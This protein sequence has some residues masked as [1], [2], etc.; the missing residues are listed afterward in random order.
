MS[1]RSAS[2]PLSS[3]LGIVALAQTTVAAGSAAGVNATATGIA[4]FVRGTSTGRINPKLLSTNDVVTG[5]PRS[6]AVLGTSQIGLSHM[7]ISSVSSASAVVEMSFIN[8]STLA[9]TLIAQ[10]WNINIALQSGDP[11]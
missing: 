4:A 6:T 8:P 1:R 11:D 3:I 5:S 9:A 7:R 10:T 2:G